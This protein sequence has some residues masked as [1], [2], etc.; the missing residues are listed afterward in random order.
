MRAKEEWVLKKVAIGFVKG[1][2]KL[3]SPLFPATCRY[4]PTC[5][6][7][8]VQAIDM[9]G[10][11]KGSTMAIARI[12]R[13]NPF[14]S[15]GVDKVPDHFTLHRNQDTINDIYLGDG[16]TISADENDV[17][18]EEIEAIIAKLEDQILVQNKQVRT[19]DYLTDLVDVEEQSVAELPNGYKNMNDSQIL[20]KQFYHTKEELE[21]SKDYHFYKIVKNKKSEPYFE[22]VHSSPIQKVYQSGQEVYCF[23]DESS[24]HIDTNSPSLE[25]ALRKNRGISQKDFNERKAKLIDYLLFLESHSHRY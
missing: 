12:I 23:I 19:V 24:G 5:S 18:Q 21:K 14:V 4:Y 9:H 6:N 22:H 1:Y 15:G 2:Q 10:A 8:A 13:C 7:Y 3:I 11:V 16:L 25:Q 20:N 17:K